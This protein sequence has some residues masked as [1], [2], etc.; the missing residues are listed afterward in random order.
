[1]SIKILIHFSPA[2]AED[3]GIQEARVSK[4]KSHKD[5]NHPWSWAFLAN[6]KVKVV[7]ILPAPSL[8][9]GSAKTA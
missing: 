2:I 5:R 6:L 9:V 1:M 8:I 3:N 4:D 7:V